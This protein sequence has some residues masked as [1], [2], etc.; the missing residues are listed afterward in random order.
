MKTKLISVALCAIFAFALTSC[1]S[2][3]SSSSSTS[4]SD[5]ASTVMSALA[6]APSSSAGQ[7]G[8]SAG[9]SIKNLY[10]NYKSAGKLDMT[11]MNNI[12]NAATLATSVAQIKD[13]YKDKAFYKDFALGMVSSATSLITNSNVDNTITSLKN[14]DLSSFQNIGSSV[15]GT[16]NTVANTASAVSSLTSLFQSFK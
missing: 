8:A 9:T 5:I 4:S 1:G 16:A 13:N 6:G 2:S 14:M 15:A 7:A 3:K 12:L 10:T 11:N